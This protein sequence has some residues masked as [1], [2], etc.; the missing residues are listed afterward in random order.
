MVE[1]LLKRVKD[2]LP[3]KVGETFKVE[4]TKV[5]WFSSNFGRKA[6]ENLTKFD[7]KVT[8][9]D[10]HMFRAYGGALMTLKGKVIARYANLDGIHL[11]LKVKVTILDHADFSAEGFARARELIPGT[12]R[13]IYAAGG[14]LQEDKRKTSP[15]QPANFWHQIEFE[16]KY[17]ILE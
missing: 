5:R 13:D 4:Q 7:G 10:E 17:D 16:S 2:D 12:L 9:I 11:V 3:N 8:K 6:F 14:T 1:G 15:K